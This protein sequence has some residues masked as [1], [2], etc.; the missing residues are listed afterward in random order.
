MLK[1]MINIF[2][3]LPMPAKDLNL[4]LGLFL[5]EQKNWCKDSDFSARF[6]F[7]ETGLPQQFFLQ[8][9]IDVEGESYLTGPRYRGGDINRPFIELI[10]CSSS[11]T[12]A[13]IRE[14]F[15]VWHPLGASLLRVLRLADQ[16]RTGRI[17]Q[18]IYAKRI[19]AETTKNPSSKILEK[20]SMSHLD[21]CM[22]AMHS[23]YQETYKQLPQLT[24]LLAPSE[25]EDVRDSIIDGNAFIIHCDGKAAGLIICEYD[26]RA[27]LS[28][29][30]ISE[31]I[32]LPESRGKHIAASAQSELT[33]LLGSGSESALLG[34]IDKSNIPSILAAERAGRSPILEY[35]F[36]KEADF[37]G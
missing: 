5:Q 27:F 30:W 11:L 36:L 19:P 24:E 12:A 35:A 20:A 7:K 4:G 37:N 9:I 21:W 33:R 28:G 16:H 3:T 1:H 34:T 18:L 22:N 6:P 17:D 10:A 26:Q 23:A 14:I 13:A 25:E 31:E 2:S 32:V 29:H 8:K 15:R